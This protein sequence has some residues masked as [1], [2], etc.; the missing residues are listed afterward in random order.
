VGETALEVVTR[1]TL[2]TVSRLLSRELLKRGDTDGL[3]PRSVSEECPQRLRARAV[4]PH[5]R[6]GGQ[7]PHLIKA[8]DI[9]VASALDL[10]S[11]DIR[12]VSDPLDIH[13]HRSSR[14]LDG[15]RRVSAQ[16]SFGSVSHEPNHRQPRKGAHRAFGSTLSLA[17]ASATRS[18]GLLGTIHIFPVS[19]DRTAETE[20]KTGAVSI[21][22]PP[23]GLPGEVRL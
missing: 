12:P 20:L 22:T 18:L 14:C 23:A 7:R 4:G 21:R 11:A 2:G 6:R 5:P 10:E 8:D 9:R 1:V 17:D 16:G 15:H 13:F 19:I 3:D